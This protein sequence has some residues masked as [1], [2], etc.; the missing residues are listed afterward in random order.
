MRPRHL[1]LGA[2]ALLV[3]AVLLLLSPRPRTDRP[4]PAATASVSAPDRSAP[5]AG[6]LAATVAETRRDGAEPAS[7]P[8]LSP[9]HSAATPRAP[10]FLGAVPPDEPESAHPVERA[11]A[12]GELLA[13]RWEPAARAGHWQRLRLMRTPVVDRTVRVVDEWREPA[14]PGAAPVAVKREMFVADQ[15]IVTRAAAMPSEEFVSRLTALG[16][17]A[18]REIA[19]GVFTARTPT[20]DLDAAPAALATLAARPDVFATPEIDGV[21]FGGATA[22][23]FYYAT[24]QW[25]LRNTGQTVVSVVGTAGVDVGA[26]AF[27]DVTTSAY[28]VVLAVLDSGLNYAHEDLQGIP[29]HDSGEIAGDGIDND[30]NGFVDDVLGWDWVNNDNNPTDDHGHGSNVTGI[31]LATRNNAVGGAGLVEGANLITAKILNAS[32]SGFTT[33]LIAATAYARLRGA[34]LMNLSLQNYPYNATLDAEFTA[35]NAAGILLVICAGNQGVN[36]DVTPNFPSSYP[37]ANI[38]AVGNHENTGIRWSGSNYGATSVDLFAPGRAIVAPGHSSPTVYFS[39]TGTSQAAP[40]VAAIAAAILRVNPT[41]SAPEVKAAILATVLTAPA[42]SGISVTGGRLQALPALAAALR[43]QPENDTDGDGWPNLLEYLTATRLDLASARPALTLD[44]IG[45]DLRLAV[46][47]T[48]R[49]DAL[50]EIEMSTDLTTWTTTGVVD[51]STAET[52]RGRMTMTGT[53]P[54]GFLRL[55]AKSVP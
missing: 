9:T 21:G 36:N 7:S 14:S 1:A 20:A 26:E 6:A 48:L 16:L 29:T 32:N 24:H 31:I 49:S 27:W 38:I 18:P 22:N 3:L 23:D 10:A 40:H 42:F 44:T 41:W 39:Y 34:R 46:P 4:A 2:A 5:P 28:G 53:P 43:A 50:L 17:V 55:R 47:R 54:R 11:A 30:G 51:E 45:N 25:N 19:P 12:A 33:H 37:H 13:E 52:L 35:C 8:P 15:V